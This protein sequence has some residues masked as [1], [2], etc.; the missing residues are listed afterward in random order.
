ME[1][2]AQQKPCARAGISASTDQAQSNE[3]L[4]VTLGVSRQHTSRLANRNL[5]AVVH[6]SLLAKTD[7][8]KCSE[9]RRSGFH[10]RQNCGGTTR[11]TLQ[12][13]T[14]LAGCT[15]TTPHSLNCEIT[16]K[17][18]FATSRFLITQKMATTLPTRL[19]GYHKRSHRQRLHLCIGIQ[20]PC[21][22]DARE[23]EYWRSSA[24][25]CRLAVNTVLLITIPG[26]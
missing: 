13:P 14:L 3:R 10:E 9:L 12:V 23:K 11:E 8:S 20:H 19:S 4:N 18:K 2:A 26:I 5:L 16:A 25:I 7:P 1:V 6:D 24:R 21:V 15:L 17:Q 22:L